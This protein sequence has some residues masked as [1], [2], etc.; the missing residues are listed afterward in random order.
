M[1]KKNGNTKAFV[2]N[3]VAFCLILINF[4]Y[5]NFLV[6]LQSHDLVMS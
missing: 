1:R 4:F 5:H 6:M 2:Y 3:S